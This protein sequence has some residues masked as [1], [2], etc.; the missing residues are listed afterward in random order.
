MSIAAAYLS[1]CCKQH[2]HTFACSFSRLCFAIALLQHPN[3]NMGGALGR[4]VGRRNDS[5][6]NIGDNW[7]H[8]SIQAWRMQVWL[9]R[10][11]GGVSGQGPPLW[12]RPS[13]ESNE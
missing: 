10:S 6:D 2:S 7:D 1:R 8:W 4:D 11:A 3:R 13:A 5:I 9:V 12:Q